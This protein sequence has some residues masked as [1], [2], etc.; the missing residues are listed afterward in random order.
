MRIDGGVAPVSRIVRRNSRSRVETEIYISRYKLISPQTER[1]LGCRVAASISSDAP[2]DERV[3]SVRTNAKLKVLSSTRADKTTSMHASSSA[4]GKEAENAR[5]VR[6][7]SWRM[8]SRAWK[9][10]CVLRCPPRAKNPI[11]I[12]FMARSRFLNNGYVSRR[13][14]ACP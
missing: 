6:H 12:G 13:I 1:V 7:C 14:V 10:C 11:F 4:R 8:H 5:N 9:A 2:C 3:Q